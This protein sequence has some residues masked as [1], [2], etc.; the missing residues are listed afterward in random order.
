MTRIGG[1]ALRA[2]RD[3]FGE[4]EQRSGDVA[5]G[6]DFLGRPDLDRFH[7]HSKHD[8]GGLI[9]GKGVSAV[10]RIASRPV[11]P[12]APIP[13]STAPTARARRTGPPS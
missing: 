7:R 3:R 9:L 2:L 5:E 11:D 13:V 4:M 1:Q 6:D 8:A 10:R 12:S